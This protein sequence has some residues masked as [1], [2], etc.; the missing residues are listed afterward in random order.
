MPAPADHHAVLAAKYDALWI[1]SAPELRAGRATLD[2]FALR[3]ADDARRGL[4]LIARPS[5]DVAAAMT[6]FL[7]ELRALEPAQYYQ[8][9]ADLHLTVLS[10]FT[11]TVEPGPYLAH[12]DTYREA[13]VEATDGT[14]AIDV[15]F[16]GVTLAPAA[17]LARGF[18][19]DDTLERLRDRLRAAIAARGLGAALDGRY[20]LETAHA[21]LVRF[22][23]PLADPARF[24]DAIDR[25]RGR[26]FGSCTIGQLTLELSDWY[27]SSET[28]ETLGTF[29]LGRH[30]R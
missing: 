3:K 13:V 8:P 24:V 29:P 17:V 30:A 23:A 25:A 20:R 19:R 1:R 9:A 21:T 15:D 5:V 7:D 2:A 26:A 12:L 11:A 14:G 6:A 22:T 4:T 18:P 16:T 10:L 27:Q 28:L